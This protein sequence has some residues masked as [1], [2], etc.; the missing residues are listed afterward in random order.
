MIEALREPVVQKR[1]VDLGHEIPGRDQMTPE[2]LA[3]YHK[4]EV[5]KWWPIMRAAC[6]LPLLW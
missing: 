4:S 1:F 6:L 3:T 2:A 5:D